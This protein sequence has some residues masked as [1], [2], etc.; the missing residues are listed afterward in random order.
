[1]PNATFASVAEDAP[2]LL[3]RGDAEGR[4]V[5]L[6]KAQRDFWGV[7]DDAVATFVWGSTLLPEDADQVYGPF[8]EGM[9]RQAPFRCEGRYRRADG[10]I[11]ILETVA[12]PRFEDGV[13]V[14]M[15]G[16]NTDVTDQR[17]AQTLLEA[18]EARQRLLVDEM[19][20]RVKNI[21]ATVLSIASLTGRS[22]PS[23]EAFN[24]AFGARLVA[25]AKTHDLLTG[26]GW[27]FAD[28]RE[29]LETELAPYDRPLTLTGDPVRLDASAAVNLALIIHELA[30]N[31]AKYGAYAGDGTLDIRW[32]VQAGSRVVLDWVETGGPPVVAPLRTGFGSR[33][34]RSL[35]KGELAGDVVTDYRLGGLVARLR[36]RASQTDARL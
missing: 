30:T 25:L 13:F 5:Y 17:A 27:A 24:A 22:A 14:G 29:V 9:A 26:Q 7:A 31:A 33:L 35:L 21:L 3:W 18:S 11:R 6:N 4:C 2:A 28:L 19:S 34:I 32:S 23:V 10:E 8:S 15:V 16:V 12:R 36:F 1:L 20:H